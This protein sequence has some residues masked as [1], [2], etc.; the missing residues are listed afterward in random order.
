MDEVQEQL[1][2]IVDQERQTLEELDQ[3]GQ[4]VQEKKQF[5]NN[6]PGK[7]SEAVE[8]LT[9]YRFENTN[10]EKEFQQLL[11][12]L[13]QI[14]KLENWLR[15]EGSLFRGQTPLQ[16]QESMDLMERMEELR[17]LEGQLS[18]MQLRD[19]DKELLEKLLGGDPKQ[20][21]EGVMRMQSLLEEGGYVLEQG[22]R[23]ELTPRGIRRVGQLALRDIYQQLRRDGMGRHSV[24]YRGSQEIQIENSRPY[25]QGDALHINMIQTLKNALLNGGG[26]PVR[27]RPGD[28]VVYDSEHTTRAATVLLLDM[29]WSMSWEG[30][31]AAAKKVAL[32]MESLVRSLHPRDYFGIVGFFTRAV[33]LKPKDLPQATWNMGDPFTNLQDGLHLAAEMLE[34]RPSP[35]QQMIV[36]TDGQPTAYCR[37]GRLYCEWPLS[38]GGISQRAAE[39]TLK[40]AE[41]ITRKGITINTFMLD[42]SPVLRGFVDDLTRINRG[43][44]F[45]TRPDR[46]GQYLLI[47][48]LSHQKKKV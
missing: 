25:V 1:E 10:A 7:A 43:R 41:R 21:F 24:R 32:A 11:M 47:D 35:N 46:L 40:E 23:F 15:R 33:E 17:R 26:V 39:E 44:A 8:K 13:E 29:S 28:F 22:D 37:Q 48:Y 30:R 3:A 34:R 16:F 20:D 36:I 9:S 18:S 42:D 38:F 31:F 27:I 2:S 14:R 5:L 6:L 19:V 4:D 45:Y 12:Q